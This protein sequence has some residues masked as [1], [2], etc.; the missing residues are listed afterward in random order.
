M[1][2]G[3][4][5]LARYRDLMDALGR[6]PF[7]AGA[8]YTQFTDVEHEKNGLLTCDRQPK[9]AADEVASLHRQ[10]LERYAAGG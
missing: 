8:C 9:V 7:L 10:L 1:G 3:A 6:M 4:E 5:L 2:S